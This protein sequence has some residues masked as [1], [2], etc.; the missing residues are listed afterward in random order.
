[1]LLTRVVADQLV[2][3]PK[4]I[5]EPIEWKAI[6]QS[7]NRFQFEAA[8]YSAETDVR[9]KLVGRL[10]PRHWSYVL[11][12]PQNARLRKISIPNDP[13]PNPDGTEMPPRHKH[14]WSEEFEDREVY[15]PNDIQWDNHNQAL[16]NFVQECNITLLH[17][18]SDFYVQARLAL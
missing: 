4:V 18:Y 7:P 1:M 11:L 2:S 10:G 16:R 15:V 12:G 17:P 5:G 14:I 6:A 8:V 9:L 3:L 13:H